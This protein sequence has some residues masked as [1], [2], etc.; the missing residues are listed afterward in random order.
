MLFDWNKE[1]IDYFIAASEFTGFHKKLSELILP[2]LSEENDLIDIGCGLGLIDLEISS[3]V[4]SITAVDENEK[5]I[6]AL[7]D[8]IK[9]L[10]ITNI[11]P[12]N[13]DY[14]E[15]KENRW[16]TLLLSFFGEPDD[17]LKALIEGVKKRA[18]LITHGMDN[19]PLRSK[20]HP[21]VKTVFVS[22]LEKYFTQ[23]GYN[24][25]KQE[26]VMDFG[27]PLK[28]YD[29][30]VNFLSCYALETDP[31]QRK[32]R[33]DEMMS[34][35]IETGDSKYPYFLPKERYISILVIER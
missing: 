31:S 5:V 24:Y 33:I 17:T 21:L 6:K 4:K 3:K 16:D 8:K 27:Q 28:S 18:I 2:Y 10:S 9:E 25:T 20:L 12:M 32:I 15:L 13:L 22:E 11:F 35:I 30:G 34:R 7:K 23:K 14:R 1:K 19:E 26:V 29:D